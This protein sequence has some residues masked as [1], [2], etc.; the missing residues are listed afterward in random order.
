ML[1]ASWFTMM[2]RRS[3]I[4]VQFDA[5]FPLAWGALNPKLGTDIKLTLVT[6]R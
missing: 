2:A 6:L 5:V 4:P 3:F 1:I